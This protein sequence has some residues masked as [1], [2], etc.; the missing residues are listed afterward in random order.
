MVANSSRGE[1]DVKVGGL[2]VR[3]SGGPGTGR[4]K[5]I[6]ASGEK[7]ENVLVAAAF[8]SLPIA[9]STASAQ[10]SPPKQPNVLLIVVD[11]LNTCLGCYGHPLV[12]SPNIDRLAKRSV[13]FERAYCQY[14]FCAPSRASLMSGVRAGTIGLTSNN[15]P[16][17]AV[18]DRLRDMVFLSELFRGHGYFTA[19]ISKIGD[20]VD[21]LFG[22]RFWDVS[23]GPHGS[24]GGRG[25]EALAGDG[26]DQHDPRTAK[27]VAE[28]L[29]QKHDKPFFIA[30]GFLRPHEPFRAPQKYYDLYPAKLIPLPAGRINDSDQ[31]TRDYIAGYYASISFMDA[32]VGL[33]LDA[34]DD[35]DLWNDT[36]VI[37]CSDH[38]F[39]LGQHRRWSKQS[40]YEEAVRVPLLVAA[41]GMSRGVVSPRLVELVDIYP[42]LTDFCGMP[43]PKG[44]EGASFRPLLT[45][46]QR[47]WK[48]AVYT[49]NKSTVAVRTERF[50]YNQRLG[51]KQR[52]LF[53][54]KMDPGE[55][56]NRADDPNYAKVVAEMQ[57]LLEKVR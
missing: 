31:Q 20:T 13:R 30:A 10:T 35:A 57:Q 5:L 28:L 19:R 39:L 45:D 47:E 4:R 32:Q 42:T 1:G 49:W 43:P 56:T 54:H 21:M 44:L 52:Q 23:E 29:Q 8:L 46:P 24:G 15:T 51:G 2:F 6:G 16:K 17:G 26:G 37:F 25:P 33:I 48:N 9:G 3:Y 36:I 7:F 18:L 41:P 50:H 14:P 53:D 11:D 27:R 22:K 38:G 55:Q 34:M 12:K 40:L